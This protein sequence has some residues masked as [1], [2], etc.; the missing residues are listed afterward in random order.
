MKQPEEYFHLLG[1][2]IKGSKSGNM[3]GWRCYTLKRK[4]FIFFDENSRQGMVFKLEKSDIEHALLHYEG[5]IFN[6]GEK[7]KPMKNWVVVDFKFHESWERL[8]H[9]SVQMILAELNNDK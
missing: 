1:K 3:F 6:P 2:S 9:S 7:G 5:R 4:P 8:L